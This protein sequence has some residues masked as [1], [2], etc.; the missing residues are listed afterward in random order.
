MQ[1]AEAVATFTTLGRLSPLSGRP[2]RAEAAYRE[3][4]NRS[5]DIPAGGRWGPKNRAVLIG[6]L[7][8]MLLRQE[9]FTEAE[10]LFRQAMAILPP[11][12]L[13]Q[14]RANLLNGLGMALAGQGLYQD[15][16]DA[17]RLGLDA[18]LASLPPD[19]PR[20]GAA[21][22]T[23]GETLLRAGQ[24][25][26]AR[27]SLEHA[28]TIQQAAGDTLRAGRAPLTLAAVMGTLWAS[29]RLP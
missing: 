24:P 1:P 4:L 23:I 7:G 19:H 11:T 20:V 28:V 22:A 25:A 26:I 5:V 21:F 27:Q 9:R 29:R 3:A 12:V 10:P 8:S 16:Y 14:V 18:L 15:A 17:H 6:N 2:E 13:D